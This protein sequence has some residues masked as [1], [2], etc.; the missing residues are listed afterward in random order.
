MGSAAAP[1]EAAAITQD[2][3]SVDALYKLIGQPHGQIQAKLKPSQVDQVRQL[4]NRQLQEAAAAE[5]ATVG[6]WQQLPHQ[7]IPSAA[8]KGRP[9]TA[10][11]SR[12]AAEAQQAVTATAERGVYEVKLGDVLAF[13]NAG[14]QQGL[15]CTEQQAAECDVLEIKQDIAAGDAPDTSTAQQQQQ[16]HRSPLMHHAAIMHFAALAAAGQPS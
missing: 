2:T 5:A 6:A 14:A 4:C 12:P 8:A 16:A 10:S 3:V 11:R 15:V 13:S 9:T 1:A 7:R